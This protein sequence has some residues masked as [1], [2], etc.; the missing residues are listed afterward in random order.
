MTS[1]LE[2]MSCMAMLFAL[3]I[4]AATGRAPKA[5]TDEKLPPAVK[6]TFDSA[7]PK[8]EIHKIDVE[9]EGGVM[10]Y[11]V[12]FKDGALEKETDIAA[13]GTMLEVT[14]VIDAKAVPSVAM[15]PIQVAAVGATMT[16]VEEIKI[17]HETKDG[18]VVKL[19]KMVTHYAVELKKG[20]QT[21]EIVVDSDGK[22]LE[23]ARFSAG[24]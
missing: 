1:R 18:K 12:E 4:L 2:L 21:A 17:T 8:A 9:E 19:P 16:R 6:K 20:D 15:K 23:E 11:D 7:F 22:V 13:D 14:V 24:K 10:V 3:E 5:A